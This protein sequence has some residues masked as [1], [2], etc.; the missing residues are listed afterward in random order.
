VVLRS[1]PSLL[2]RPAIAALDRLRLARKLV[3]IALVLI[4]PALY[5]TWEFRSQQDD[6]IAFSSKERVGVQEIVP[7][8][9]L[10]TELANARALA[11]R[12]TGGDAEATAALPAARQRVAAATAALDAADRRL[13]AQLGHRR[14]VEA[15][16]DV[17]PGHRA[18]APD[19]RARR[20]GRLRPPDR[21]HARAHRPGRQ[22][23]EPHPRPDL[24]SYYAM[25]AFVN[26][27]PWRWTR[28]AR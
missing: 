25:D 3:V 24:D 1:L 6:Q 16:A 15:A 22:R 8:S 26:K 13:G 7:A 21:G 5:A 4:A 12:S 10:L 20:A 9:T 28:P 27:V 23:V 14:D 19:R 2:L 11:V 17:D 18:R